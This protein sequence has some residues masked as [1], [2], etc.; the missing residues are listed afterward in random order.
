MRHESTTS[1]TVRLF[2]MLPLMVSLPLALLAKAAMMMTTTMTNTVPTKMMAVTMA[3][4][5]QN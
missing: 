5:L 4:H 1:T 2:R 3:R